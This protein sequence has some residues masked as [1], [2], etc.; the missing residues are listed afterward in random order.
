MNPEFGQNEGLLFLFDPSNIPESELFRKYFGWTAARMSV[1]EDGLK[2][3][4]FTETVT[5]SSETGDG[6][7]DGKES[8]L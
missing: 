4:Q 7:E 1:V 2:I 8:E 6:A 3:Y 5:D